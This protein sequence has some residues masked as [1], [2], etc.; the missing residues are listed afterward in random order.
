MTNSV[1]DLGKK[2]QFQILTSWETLL[3]PDIFHTVI[4]EFDWSKEKKKCVVCPQIDFL[5]TIM[6]E[7]LEAGSKEKPPKKNMKFI[8]LPTNATCNEF[9]RKTPVFA[10][11]L[12]FFF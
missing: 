10:K 5:F 7:I 11:L 6:F 8:S 2:M 9:Y 4:E 12:L 1:R 3:I